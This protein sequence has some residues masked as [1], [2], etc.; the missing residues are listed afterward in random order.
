MGDNGLPLLCFVTF[1]HKFN[2]MQTIK[3]AISPAFLEK[4]SVFI[5]GL[6]S[7]ISLVMFILYAQFNT[8]EIMPKPLA[9][10]I[11]IKEIVFTSNFANNFVATLT[12]IASSMA[13]AVGIS[14]LIV[15]LFTI[16]IFRPIG[17]FVSKLRFLTYTGLVFVFT[18]SLKDGHAIKTSLL[19]FGIIPYFVTSLLSYIDSIAKIE[20]E[21]C[22]TLRFGTWRTLYEVII[23]GKMHLV[24]E[25]IRQNFAIAWMMITSVEGLSMSEG[26]LGTMMIKSN[27]YLKMDDVFAVLVIILLVGILFDYIFDVLK[28]WIFP[29]CDTKR[30]NRLWINR[31][32]SFFFKKKQKLN[33][34]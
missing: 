14:L 32:T 25:V 24:F 15:Y 27:K 17:T 18:I 19:L 1:T 31:L 16:P 11:S 13:K 21:L 7:V 8:S 12:L 5:I 3:K 10:A 26:G 23:R 2:N 4:P 22:Y 30:N 9:V 20:Y 28:V 34:S 29:Y 6:F 33:V